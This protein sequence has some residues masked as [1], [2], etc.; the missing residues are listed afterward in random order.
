MEKEFRYKQVLICLQE[1]I[2]SCFKKKMDLGFSKSI[3]YDGLKI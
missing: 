1:E 3:K 2:R